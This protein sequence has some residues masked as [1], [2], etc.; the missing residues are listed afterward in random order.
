MLSVPWIKPGATEFVHARDWR[1]TADTVRLAGGVSAL[2][3]I[4]DSQ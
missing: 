4:P 2:G 1:C 3:I